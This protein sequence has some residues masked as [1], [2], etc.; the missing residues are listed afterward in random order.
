VQVLP[1]GFDLKSLRAFVVAVELGGMTQAAR[2]LGMTQS[3]MSQI[4]R[5][6]EEAV[7][8]S[9]F[10]RSARP[11]TPTSAGYSFHHQAREILTLADESLKN[12][13][14]RQEDTV[15]SLTIAMPD[16][17]ANTI[18]A[19]L[20]ETLRHKAN[21]LQLWSG[22]SP[23]H[24][25]ALLSRSV[26][27]V[28][29]ASDALIHTEGLTSRPLLSEPYVVALP[30]DHDGATDIKTLAA[31]LPFIRYT[32]RSAIGRQIEGQLNRMKVRPPVEMEFDTA[33]S[34]LAAVGDGMGWSLTTPLCLRQNMSLLAGLTVLPLERGRFGR[35]L[36]LISRED[37]HPDIAAATARDAGSLLRSE[38]IAPIV[39]VYPWIEDNISWPEDEAQIQLSPRR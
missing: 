32:L 19:R 37:W 20:L 18:G 17:I 39:K 15:P 31:S 29:T 23:H 36:S 11:I 5:H 10:D 25:D 28:I 35:S 4:I 27:M 2:H 24:H 6:L 14:R 3:N 38:A 21:G 1:K 22:I 30:H 16:T 13:G 33:P 12:I 7:G 34:Q 9:L 26:D 8:A